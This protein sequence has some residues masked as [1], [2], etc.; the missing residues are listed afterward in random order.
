VIDSDVQVLKLSGF[1]RAIR[2]RRAAFQTI[3]TG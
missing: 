1:V 2:N 3:Y